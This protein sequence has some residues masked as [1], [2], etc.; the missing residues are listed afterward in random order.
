MAAEEIRVLAAGFRDANHGDWFRN[1]YLPQGLPE[2]NAPSRPSPQA[3]DE[4]PWKRV[5]GRR[6]HGLRNKPLREI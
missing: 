1:V 2:P 6:H 3:N 4:R 5:A